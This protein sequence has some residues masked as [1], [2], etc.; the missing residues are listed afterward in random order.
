MG[1]DNFLKGKVVKQKADPLAGDIN[2][3]GKSGIGY[4][5]AGANRLNSAYNEDPSQVVN[6]QIGIENKLARAA[7]SDATRRTQGL[8]AQRGLGSSSIGLGAEM[9]QR[10][11]LMDT[12]AINNASG[13]SR[14]R[15]MQ[16]QNGQG[17]ID[18]GNSL[19]N[20]KASQGPVQMQTTKSRQGGMAAL[21]GGAAGAYFGPEGAK[22]GMGLG[23]AYANS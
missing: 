3:A 23:Q 12:L 16:I 15:D 4:L 8:I 14:I 9:G 2:A 5:T 18:A 11:S 13:V 19:W 17:Q 7:A 10:K 6:T 20:I 21:I 1:L 22:V